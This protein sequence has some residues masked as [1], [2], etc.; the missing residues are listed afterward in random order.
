MSATGE[1]AGTPP[2]ID[3]LALANLKE[4]GGGDPAFVEELIVMFRED[5]PPRL[6]SID[7][8]LASGDAT[9]I[10]K[11]AHSLKGSAAN[12]GAGRFR[13]LSQAIESAG[14]SGDLST[15]P[16]LLEQLKLEYT[17]VQEALDRAAAAGL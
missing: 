3:P 16:P 14:K 13:E 7:A 11:D 10:A 17:R 5:S 15:V 6:V 8:G 12:F 2:P 4:I 9:G 1:S